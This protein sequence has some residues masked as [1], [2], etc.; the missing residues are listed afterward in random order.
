M[1]RNRS[2]SAPAP[3]RSRGRTRLARAAAVIALVGVAGTVSA[4]AVQAIEFNDAA[5]LDKAQMSHTEGWW[6]Y[7]WDRTEVEGEGFCND[8]YTPYRRFNWPW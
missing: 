6:E 5:C 2:G 1:D 7:G 8:I 4:P 3:D